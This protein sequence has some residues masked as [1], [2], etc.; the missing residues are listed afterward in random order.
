[1]PCEIIIIDSESS[2]NTLSLSEEEKCL[3]RVISREDFRHG[4]VRNQGAELATGDILLFLTQD[5]LPANKYFI[6]ILTEP[7][8]KGLAVASYARQI[9]EPFASPPEVF[10]RK[11]NYPPESMIRTINDVEKMGIKAYFFSD[12]ASAVKRDIF[13]SVGGFSE[14]IIVNEDMYLCATILKKGYSVAYQGKALVYHSHDYKLLKLF[15]RYFDIGVFFFQASSLLKGAATGGEGIRFI[16]SLIKYLVEK[17]EWK[18]IPRVF[19]E[20][21]IKYTAFKLGLNNRF[22][23][24]SI[25]K[26]LSGQPS[27][28]TR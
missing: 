27:Y 26:L 9:A 18:W 14:K 7:L 6:E 19:I 15:R 3:T 28:W 5:V 1:M 12:A 20:T 8:I 24:L 10:A 17:G 4:R 23:P 22:L 16:Y 13:L 2:D 11:F 21:F 25:K